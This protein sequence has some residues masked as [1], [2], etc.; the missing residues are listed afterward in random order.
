MSVNDPSNK[1]QTT[2]TIIVATAVLYNFMRRRND[3]IDDSHFPSPVVEELPTMHGAVG[4]LGN[5][6]RVH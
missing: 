5:A 6:M 2:L 3:P 1:L 4:G